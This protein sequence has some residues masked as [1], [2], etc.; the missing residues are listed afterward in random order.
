MPENKI[1]CQINYLIDE[2]L[3]K[4]YFPEEFE[5]EWIRRHIAHHPELDKQQQTVC[6]TTGIAHILYNQ[7]APWAGEV[8]T[9]SSKDRSIPNAP[10]HYVH[11]CVIKLH[12][13]ES[14]DETDILEKLAAVF[15]P[16]E[17]SEIKIEQLTNEE[18]KR[19]IEEVR[20]RRRRKT[21]EPD[22][23]KIQ[24]ELQQFKLR[25]GSG[26]LTSYDDQSTSSSSTPSSTPPRMPSPPKK[27]H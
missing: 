14:F 7:S 10:K 27:K 19:R 26:F 1:K 25:W 23:D 22:P 3:I 9:M 18:V 20:A 2:N 24:A 4:L 11:V 5:L 8:M 13:D 6:Y 17:K 12:E 15:G 21:I 16:I